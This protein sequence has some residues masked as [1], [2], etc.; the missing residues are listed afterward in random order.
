MNA[1]LLFIFSKTRNECTF[2][3][4]SDLVCF[5]IEQIHTSL[6]QNIFFQLKVGSRKL[7]EMQDIS[8]T[9]L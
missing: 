9:K 8:L 4:E 2:R 3:H 5:A 6:C 7:F 1:N